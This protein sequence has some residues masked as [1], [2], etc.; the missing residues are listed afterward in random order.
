MVG[1]NRPDLIA[2]Y[3]SDNILGYEACAFGETLRTVEQRNLALNEKLKL[4]INKIKD[5]TQ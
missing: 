1:W 3:K 2:R 5:A 4:Y